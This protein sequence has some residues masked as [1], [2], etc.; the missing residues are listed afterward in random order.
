VG[1]GKAGTKQKGGKKESWI[2]GK[3]R[4]C[5]TTRQEGVSWGME[6]DCTKGEE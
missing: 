6:C 2:N 3:Q 4:S 5:V 1:E